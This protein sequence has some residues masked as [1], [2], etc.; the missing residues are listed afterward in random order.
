MSEI[1][2]VVPLKL[3]MGMFKDGLSSM[4]RFMAAKKQQLKLQKQQQQQA[5][6]QPGDQTPKLSKKPIPQSPILQL[7]TEDNQLSPPPVP[8]TS[9]EVTFSVTAT[10][11]S[12]PDH[13]T[14]V[15][16]TVTAEL[17]AVTI[18][19]SPL[20][21]GSGDPEAIFSEQEEEIM[22]RCFVFMLDLLLLQV[23][24]GTCAC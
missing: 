9:T 22:L 20:I 24:G 14:T 5:Q 16:V 17:P 19:P 10:T 18:D 7:P 23:T 2:L 13:T 21:Q 15:P 1:E 3:L 12:S 8:A 4:S 6:Q 11:T